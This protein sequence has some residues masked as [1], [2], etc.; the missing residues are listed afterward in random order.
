E[1]DAA[2]AMDD[3]SVVVAATSG[4]TPRLLRVELDNGRTTDLAA[5]YSTDPVWSPDGSA[6]VY[7]GADVGTTFPLKSMT[8]DGRPAPLAPVTLSRGARR[9]AFLPGTRS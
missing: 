5:E 8:I 7:S 2:W 4:G 6:I 3:R 9:L 1:G